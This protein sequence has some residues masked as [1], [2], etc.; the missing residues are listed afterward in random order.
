MADI[1]KKKKKKKK[2]IKYRRPISINI[3]FLVFLAIFAYILIYMIMYFTRVRVSIYEVVYGKNADLTNR[4]Y[5]GLLLRSESVVSADT[6]GYLNYYVKSGE[7]ASVG[8]TVCTIDE[9][10]QIQKYLKDNEQEMEL[11][12]EDYETLRQYISDFTTEYSDVEFS[13]TYHFKIDLSSKLLEC[14]NMNIINEKLAELSADGNYNYVVNK[15]SAAGIVEYYSDGY[16]GKQISEISADDFNSD[17]YTRKSVAPNDLLEQGNPIYKIISEE[18]WKVLLLLSEDEAKQRQEDTRIKIRFAKDGTTAVGDFE[19]INQNNC[20]IGV[21]TLDK[22]MIKYASER[23]ATIQI[24]EEEVEGLKIPKT[25]IITKDF[26]QVP[27]DFASK[28]GD[29]DETGYYKRV[30]DENNQ[31]TIK[32]TAP[33]IYYSDEQYYYIDNE[34][35]EKGDVIIKNDSSET[36]TIGQTSSIEGVYNVNSGYCVFRRVERLAESGDYFLVDIGTSYGLKVY[37][38]IVLEGNMVTE[39]EVVFR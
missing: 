17:N 39:N 1:N 36:F 31:M 26:F 32:F 38:H 35:F 37:D 9:N 30:Y 23:Y 12:A 13:K 7:R 2:V 28:G 4:T 5:N 21:V 29:S 15:S 25:S 16:E 11:K 27:K 19:I 14:A 10:G 8:T 3:G 20:Y 6:A 24:V 18:E 33:E 22:Y 34:D